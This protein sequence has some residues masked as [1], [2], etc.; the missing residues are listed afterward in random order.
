M[1]R[2]SWFEPESSGLAFDQYV[3]KME[4]WQSALAD[5]V[6]E[7]AEVEQQ[8]KHLAEMLRELEPKL[9]DALHEELTQVFY[10]LAV[11]YGMQQMVE[12][13]IEQRGER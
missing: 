6:V 2:T 13:A 9:S 12:L 5:G 4:S 7:P 3:D 1:A 11:L 8:A 10:E